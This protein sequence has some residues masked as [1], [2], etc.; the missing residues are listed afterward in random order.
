MAYRVAAEKDADSYQA[1]VLV[2]GDVDI[3]EQGSASGPGQKALQAHTTWLILHTE[4]S[5]TEE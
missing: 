1:M 3:P 5:T 4:L 2:L